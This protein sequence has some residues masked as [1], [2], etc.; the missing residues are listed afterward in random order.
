MTLTGKLL[1]SS[2]NG[3]Q[4]DQQLLRLALVGRYVIVEFEDEVIHR[5]QVADLDFLKEPIFAVSLPLVTDPNFLQRPNVVQ[6]QSQKIS[7]TALEALTSFLEEEFLCRS[8][9]AEGLEDHLTVRAGA[10]HVAS[11][12]VHFARY[13][14]GGKEMRRK[15]RKAATK[16]KG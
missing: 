10:V 1:F 2:E 7:A 16:N 13:N 6:I 5:V 14:C 3:R 11:V 15:F 4:I 8:S 9:S 12:N